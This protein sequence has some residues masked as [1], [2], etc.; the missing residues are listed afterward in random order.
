MGSENPF[1]RMTICMI[2][3][4]QY[5]KSSSSSTTFTKPFQSARFPFQP[6]RTTALP[7]DACQR[8]LVSGSRFALRL[9]T[10]DACLSVYVPVPLRLVISVC[11]YDCVQSIPSKPIPSPILS[12]LNWSTGLTKRGRL[13]PIR[14]AFSDLLRPCPQIP[15]LCRLSRD[16]VQAMHEQSIKHKA[17]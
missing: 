11:F 10:A 16:L 7:Y 15:A 4:F 17:S 3:S 8:L 2:S 6:S 13:L 5:L 14:S 12:E 1:L 9:E